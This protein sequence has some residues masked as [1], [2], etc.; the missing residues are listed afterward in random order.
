MIGRRGRF[1]SSC[2]LKFTARLDRAASSSRGGVLPDGPEDIPTACA[3]SLCR[4]RHWR[5]LCVQ[6]PVLKPD[7]TRYGGTRRPTFS[8]PQT[9]K[10]QGA[11]LTPD[12]YLPPGPQTVSAV[13]CA[14]IP[15]Q[16]CGK[17]TIG[18][19]R[20]RAGLIPWLGLLPQCSGWTTPPQKLFR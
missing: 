10:S 13:R 1:Y 11:Q 17:R 3:S 4:D 6:I 14:E 2:S 19:P 18:W 9:G 15:F 16:A 5:F 8:S 12:P 7:E 20:C